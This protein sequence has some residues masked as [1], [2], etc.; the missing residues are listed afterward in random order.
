LKRLKVSS[1]GAFFLGG[2]EISF[3]SKKK[4]MF[5]FVFF[6]SGFRR[7]KCRGACFAKREKR[8]QLEATGPAQ[9]KPGVYVAVPSAHFAAAI[10]AVEA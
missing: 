1:R 9:C 10:A 2:G 7:R 5:G 4:Q 8:G 3:V 6:L